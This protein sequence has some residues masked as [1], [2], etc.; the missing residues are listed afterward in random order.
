MNFSS[1]P[2][3]LINKLFVCKCESGENPISARFTTPDPFVQNPG[4]SQDYNRYSYVNNNPL[5]YTDPS[6]YSSIG[7]GYNPT[8]RA[9]TM[10][11]TQLMAYSN[12]QYD[13]L[14]GRGNYIMGGG[15]GGAIGYLSY[16]GSLLGAGS[17][18]GG[19]NGLN[20]IT[21]AGTAYIENSYG[22]TPSIQG[23]VMGSWTQSYSTV[24]GPTQP[25]VLPAFIVTATFT[26]TLITDRSVSNTKTL[27][28]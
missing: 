5:K 27:L 19:L 4:F 16:N 8:W 20:Q 23:G 11:I 12:D 18:S 13:F 25:G 10:Q 15:F 28:D 3:N 21:E 24:I 2:Y 26:P 6:G 17:V 14:Y 7:C 9:M 22:V 1:T